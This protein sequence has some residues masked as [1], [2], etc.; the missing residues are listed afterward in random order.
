MTFS[1]LSNLQ[2]ACQIVIVLLIAAGLFM[3]TFE[4]T[5]F[6]LEGFIMVIVASVISGIRWS[7]AQILT[8]KE[9]LGEW[10]FNF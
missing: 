7:C 2:H 10:I 5:Q 9:E 1:P 6:N 8:Q 4:S 3:F